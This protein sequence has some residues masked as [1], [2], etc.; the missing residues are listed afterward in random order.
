MGCLLNLEDSEEIFDVLLDIISVELDLEFGLELDVA[1]SSLRVEELITALVAVDCGN[2]TEDESGGI[3][4]ATEVVV[5]NCVLVGGTSVAMLLVG[6]CSIVDDEMTAGFEAMHS[7]SVFPVEQHSVFPL[8]PMASLAQ[9]LV[10]RH[11][12]MHFTL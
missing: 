7:C 3:T 6:L 11:T 12:S 5:S 2:P 1:E 9:K 10:K 8:G 4:L